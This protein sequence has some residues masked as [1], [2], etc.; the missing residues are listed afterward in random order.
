MTTQSYGWNLQR[1]QHSRNNNTNICRLTYQARGQGQ[2]LQ[3]QGQTFVL[4]DPVS[5]TIDS[6]LRLG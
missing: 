4:D 5:D 2:Y 1:L 6:Q 3:G